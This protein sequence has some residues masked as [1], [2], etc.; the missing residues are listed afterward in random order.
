MPNDTDYETPEQV[1]SQLCI[2]PKE[3]VLEEVHI[4]DTNWIGILHHLINN[5]T[6]N[7]TIHLNSM[8]LNTTAFHKMVVDS[9]LRTTN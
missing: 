7:T 9:I 1:Y 5:I 3:V 6:T 2:I 8:S 4:F